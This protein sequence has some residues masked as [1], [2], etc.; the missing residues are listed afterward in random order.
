MIVA[1]LK[2]SKVPHDDPRYPDS[3]AVKRADG[4]VIPFSDVYLCS[5]TTDSGEAFECSY[6]VYP[7]GISDKDMTLRRTANMI[8]L[9]ADAIERMDEKAEAA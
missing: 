5:V 3:D 7:D 8:R 9:M 6:C 2:V 1:D 4:S